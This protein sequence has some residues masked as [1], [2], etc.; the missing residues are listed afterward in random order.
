MS[1]CEHHPGRNADGDTSFGKKFCTKC[2]EQIKKAQSSVSS[3]VNPK[4]CFIIYKGGATGWE[5]FYGTGCAHW[6]AH[7]RGIK[8]G[9]SSDKCALGYSIKVPDVISGA[10]KIENRAE[11]RTGDIWVNDKSIPDHCGIVVKV[12]SEGEK[13]KI[14]IRHCS[15][16]QGGVV[17]NDFDA[18]WSGK[19]KFYRR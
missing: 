10:H 16:G 18:H 9:F 8:Y 15:S 4:E 14:S 1:K 5:T 19:G 7:Q 13:V 17:T 12:E 2:A 11:V 6:V 3:H